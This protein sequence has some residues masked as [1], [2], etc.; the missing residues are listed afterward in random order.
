MN[1]SEW[2]DTIDTEP[3]VIS[4][5]LLPLTTLLSGIRGVGFMSHAINLYLRCK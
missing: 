5:H 2:L 3:D 1:H 4:M